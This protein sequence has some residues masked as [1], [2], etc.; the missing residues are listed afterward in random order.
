[1]DEFFVSDILAVGLG[2][3]AFIIGPLASISWGNF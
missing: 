3:L 2:F 1:L